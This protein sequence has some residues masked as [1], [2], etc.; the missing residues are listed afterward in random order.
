MTDELIFREEDAGRT[1]KTQNTQPAHT[2]KIIIADDEPAVHDITVL[3]LNDIE[4]DQRKLQFLHAYSGSKAVELLRNNPDTA[5]LLLDVVMETDDAGLKVVERVRNELGNKFVRIILRTGQPGQAPEHRVIQQYDINDYKEKTELTSKKLFTTVITALRSYHDIMRL[6]YN[7]RGLEKILSATS[8]VFRLQSM[9]QL[10]SGVLMQVMSIIGM[11]EDAFFSHASGLVS[12]TPDKKTE[13]TPV[14]DMLVISATGRFESNIN[15]P[16]SQALDATILQQ[17]ETARSNKKNLYSHD[18]CVVYLHHDSLIY[19]DG[20]RHLGEL[21]KKLLDIFCANISVAFENIELNDEILDTQKEIIFTLGSTT[22]FRCRETG[23]HIVRVSELSK[24]LAQLIGLADDEAELIKLAAPMHDVGKIGIPDTILLKP[25]KL[26]VDEYEVMKTHTTIGYE[27]LK[28]S[29]RPIFKAAAIIA[30]EH[31]ERWDG[32][33]YPR[34]LAGD[35]IHIYGRIIALVDV[36]DALASKRCYKESWT[37]EDIRQ[38]FIEMR[39]KYYDPQL[40]D[41]LLQNFD[42]FIKLREQ[43]GDA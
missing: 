1:N 13:V 38:H 39:G 21:E 40:V 30:Y 8:N 41:L 19:I 22:E 10:T 3:A 26:T 24:K 2:W 28:T 11:D 6:D 17:I 16:I 33:G 14:S 23:N 18:S 5:L 25:G 43:F 7:R 15:Q 4:Y 20:H 32:S 27:L 35:K 42:G 12:L 37:S 36:F 9:E 31:Q 29:T 34:G